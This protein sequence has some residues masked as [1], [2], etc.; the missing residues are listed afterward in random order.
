MKAAKASSACA[1]CHADAGTNLLRGG[2]RLR[3]SEAAC[4]LAGSSVEGAPGSE[5]C[6]DKPRLEIPAA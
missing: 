4:M 6:W 3:S 5:K 2:M 1:S